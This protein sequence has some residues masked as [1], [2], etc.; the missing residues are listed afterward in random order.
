M[1]NF[2]DMKI[3]PSPGG[4]KNVTYLFGTLVAKSLPLMS[5]CFSGLISALIKCSV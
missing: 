2:W 1:T 5:G 4:N 3:Y